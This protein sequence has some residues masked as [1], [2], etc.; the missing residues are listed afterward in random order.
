VGYRLREVLSGKK[1]RLRGP[2]GPYW[3]YEFDVEKL[4]RIARKYGYMFVLK[5]STD[6][7]SQGVF[8]PFTPLKVHENHVESME[9]S[10]EKLVET[11]L[12]V[13]SLEN[14]RTNQLKPYNNEAKAPTAFSQNSL[15]S[16]T[17]A[18]KVKSEVKPLSNTRP[19]L[20]EVLEKINFTFVEGTEEE[21]LAHAI[22][23]GLTKDEAQS[24]FEKL[25]GEK[26]FWFDRDGKTVWRWV[27]E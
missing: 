13:S 9:K 26:L 27:H 18:P 25:K 10:L 12:E 22:D 1:R 6:S 3:A 7:T 23:A 4:K 15:F 21:F 20:A 8:T 24:L 2:E 17:E 11:P 14:S 5:F 16:S 19:S